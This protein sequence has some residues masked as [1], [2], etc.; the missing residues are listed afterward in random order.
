[1]NISILS[2]WSMNITLVNECH[3]HEWMSPLWMNITLTK[4]DHPYEIMFLNHEIREGSLLNLEGTNYAHEYCYQS[5]SS[6]MWYLK[7]LCGC[8]CRQRSPSSI[9]IYNS[10]TAACGLTTHA[11]ASVSR[12]CRQ[13]PLRNFPFFSSYLSCRL[14]EPTGFSRPW[15]CSAARVSVGFHFK[16]YCNMLLLV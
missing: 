13:L 1:M 10:A 12:S 14:P 3:P 5:G 4:V 11:A 7:W 6:V 9:K 16:I 15:H 8:D 2:P